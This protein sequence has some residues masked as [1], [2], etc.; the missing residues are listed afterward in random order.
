MNSSLRKSSRERSLPHLRLQPLCGL[1]ERPCQI[2]NAWIS[3]MFVVICRIRLNF[4]QGELFTVCMTHHI[5]SS[6]PLI[7][8]TT[9]VYGDNIRILIFLSPSGESL[10]SPSPNAHRIASPA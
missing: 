10:P 1:K 8:F 4:A 9:M 2:K 3:I 7:C 5:S 6:C